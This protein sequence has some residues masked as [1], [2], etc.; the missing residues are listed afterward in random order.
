MRGLLSYPECCV[1]AN[2]E[3]SRAADEAFL[4]ALIAKVGDEP[5]AIEK[6]IRE[7]LEVE[8]P[9]GLVTCRQRS[10]DF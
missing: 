4:A 5:A 7:D 9:D 10:K 3:E 2:V 6:A 1:R 8:L